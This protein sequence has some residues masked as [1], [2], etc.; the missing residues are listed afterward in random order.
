MLGAVPREQVPP[1]LRSADAVVC[2]PWYEPFGIVALEA[3][4]HRCPVVVAA[5]GGLSEVVRLHETGL[6]CHPG[7]PESLA[8]AVLETLH[9]PDWARARAENAYREAV[10]LYDWG[11]VAQKT[12]GTYRRVQ[13]EAR[14]NPWS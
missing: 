5:T 12:I 2:A 13:Q 10:D 14:Q 1:L 7:N 4:I 11:R 3:M 8:W 9:H 6:T